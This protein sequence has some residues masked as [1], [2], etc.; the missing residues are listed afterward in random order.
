MNNTAP[1]LIR[2]LGLRDLSFFLIA[3]LVNLNSVPV[4]AGAGPHA[5]ALWVTGFVLFFI[6]QAIAVLELS[7]RSPQ[8]GGIYNWNKAAFGE[9][10]GF[11]SGWSYWVN[12]IFYIPTLLFYII[13]FLAYIGGDTTSWLSSNLLA[14]TLI[15]LAL[16][17]F[18]TWLNIRG[19]T[20]GKWVQNLGASG[21]FVTA[22][23][24]MV[25]A[26]IAF[27]NR[28][29]SNEISF[30][31]VIPSPSDLGAFAL[32]S[33]VC[34]NYV[35][36]ELG[37]VIG[38]EIKEPRKNIPR[39]VMI[40]GVSTVALFLVVTTSLLVAIP[41]EEIGII[42]G[43][44]QGIEKAA[45][46]IGIAWIVIPM[47]LLMSMNAAG[48]TSAWLSGAAR[49][50][51]VIGIDRYLPPSLGYIHPRHHTPS[52]ALIVQGAASSAVIIMGAIGSS[53]H[54]M[55]LILLQT[56]VVLQLIPYLYMFVALTRVRRTYHA[57]PGYFSG[58]WITSSAGVIGAIMTFF[59]IAFAF[60]P[61]GGIEDTAAYEMKL[62]FGCIGFLIPGL[63]FYS[64]SRKNK[65]AQ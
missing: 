34:L 22:A 43:I 15:S 18:L 53:V 60:I 9:F 58:R 3:A 39:A 30:S 51:F 17:W 42:E 40:A 12:N 5:I 25:I 33:V 8:E 13:G 21:T 52:V 2:T 29:A 45:G 63:V 54:D 38:D 64:L 61:S 55:Y 7:H 57:A 16:L 47:G 10:H 20:V 6:P 48:N 23:T 1:H 36:L 27:V 62:I 37:A 56:T 50:P 4:I 65:P 35:G 24:I 44:L 49:I 11:L 28:G 19:F 46:E 26:V 32:L 14:M 31:S 41:T 59:G